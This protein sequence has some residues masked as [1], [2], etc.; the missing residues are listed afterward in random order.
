ME[1]LNL[2]EGDSHDQLQHEAALRQLAQQRKGPPQRG[3]RRGG[4]IINQDQIDEAKKQII[5]DSLDNLLK[6]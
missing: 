6:Q 5:S 3:G 1:R 2:G 4:I